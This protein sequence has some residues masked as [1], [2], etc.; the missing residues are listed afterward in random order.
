DD[1]TRLAYSELTRPAIEQYIAAHPQISRIGFSVNGEVDEVSDLCKTI[2]S[3]EARFPGLKIDYLK[4]AGKSFLEDLRST[5][6]L[7]DE[8][9]KPLE[10]Q[11]I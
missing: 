1:V 2:R 5:L 7:R 9:E 8:L 11:L 4:A 3:I 6:L 10:R